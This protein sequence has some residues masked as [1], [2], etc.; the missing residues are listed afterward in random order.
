M[1]TEGTTRTAEFAGGCAIGQSLEAVWLAE[2][3]AEGRG[4]ISVYRKIPVPRQGGLGH[5]E[6]GHRPTPVSQETALALELAKPRHFIPQDDARRKAAPMFRGLLGYFPA[7]LFAVAEHSM[8]SDLK[9]NPGNPEAPTWAR[10]KSS[11]HPDCIVRH[12]I[13]AG[14]PGTPDRLYHLRAL[15]WR[16]LAQLQEEL[17]AS[18]AKP[19]VSSRFLQLQKPQL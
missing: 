9:H 5:D 16:S 18:G 7:A 17:E 6:P 3:P 1:W 13:D 19:G 11:D 8:E 14:Q 10:G 2:S 4:P 12:L 15:A